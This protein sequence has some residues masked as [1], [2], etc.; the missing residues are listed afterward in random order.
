M[1]NCPTCGKSHYIEQ[2]TCSTAMYCSIEWKDGEI[3]SEDNNYHTTTCTCLEC[4]NS[5]IIHTHR[6]KITVEK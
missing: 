1:I 5:F 4:H 3:V 2:Y 6:N